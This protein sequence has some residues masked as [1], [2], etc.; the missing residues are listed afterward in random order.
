MKRSRVSEQS[1]DICMEDS[2][3]SLSPRSHC[4]YYLMSPAAGKDFP[5]PVRMSFS[6]QSY[7]EKEQIRSSVR[8]SVRFIST[9]G[10]AEERIMALLNR[11]LRKSHGRLFGGVC[12]C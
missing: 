7:H 3:Q 2:C 6:I 1:E 5:G 10:K 11:D 8:F 4:H 12:I 9:A